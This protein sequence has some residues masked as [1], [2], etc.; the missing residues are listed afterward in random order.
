MDKGHV[1]DFASETV[2]L[3]VTS[4]NYSFPVY[5]GLTF[6]PMLFDKPSLYI[7]QSDLCSPIRID[8][9]E[10][11]QMYG[12]ELHQYAIKFIDFNNCTNASDART[13]PEVD[14]LD[15]S[16]CI[17]RELTEKTIFFSKAHFHGAQNE[18]IQ[19][20]KIDGFNA[21]KEKHDSFLYFE[22]Y[23]G[24]PIKAVYRMQLNIDATID[25]IKYSEETRES[26]PLK[27]KG[28]RRIL[29]VV[30][31]DQEVNLDDKVIFQL[32][33]FQIIFFYGRLILISAAITLSIVFIGCMEFFGRRADKNNRYN[34]GC[35][36]RTEGSVQY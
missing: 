28:V 33:M 29:P 18:T 17:S 23:T 31:L 11:V 32:K 1:L 16:K 24:T 19:G 21:S 15:V 6:A 2:P 3:E 14:M 5:D 13:C 7:F 12:M 9:V 25:P 10:K 20:L 34:R 4:A 8:F 36:T 27:K 26:E 30:W 35:Y 22:P